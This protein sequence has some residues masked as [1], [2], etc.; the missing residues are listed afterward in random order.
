MKTYLLLILCL[1]VTG[2][3]Q[4]FN[5]REV[6]A[7]LKALE[8]EMAKR[9]V[10]VRWAFADHYQI[11][12][13]VYARG[14]E[15]VAEFLTAEKVSPEQVAQIA[16]YEAL[17]QQLIMKSRPASFAL[18]PAPQPSRAIRINTL[19][20]S[21]PKGLSD[22]LPPLPL[23]VPPST[24]PPTPPAPPEPRLPTPEEKEYEALT[25]RVAEVKA[26]VAALIE[27]RAQITA[28]YYSREFLEQLVADY[29]KDR[30]DLVV[31]F[32][33]MS[34]YD[35]PVLYRS[36]GEVPDITEGIIKFF[37]DKEKP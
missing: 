4:E 32:D 17:N 33:R 8:T 6:L 7:R 24:P 37:R 3:G 2:Y 21:P 9:P 20:P 13:V 1:A 26:P 35:K 12:N 27:R 28:K 11:R 10:P 22:G 14:R 19:P 18:P 34:S 16:Q 15:K 30:F 29:A 5:Q 31:N 25:K 23:L 36:T